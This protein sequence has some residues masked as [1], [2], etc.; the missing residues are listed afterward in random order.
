LNLHILSIKSKDYCPTHYSYN[1]I[2][3]DQVKAS[4]EQ[5]DSPILWTCSTMRSIHWKRWM[6][7]H[8]SQ[9]WQKTCAW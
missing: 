8:F 3:T 2:T 4:V 9:L 6:K 1:R 5:R 7:L